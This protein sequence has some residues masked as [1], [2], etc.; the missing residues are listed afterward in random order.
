MLVSEQ[1]MRDL[2]TLLP[3][4]APLA[5]PASVDC[6]NAR[7]AQPLGIEPGLY[8][9][10]AGAAYSRLTIDKGRPLLLDPVVS[11]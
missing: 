3:I 9:V 8:L 11:P 10:D 4:P 1:D 7:T 5:K 2:R 6:I